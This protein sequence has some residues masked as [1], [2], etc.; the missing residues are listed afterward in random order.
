MYFQV[1]TFYGLEVKAWTEIQSEKLA[2]S[3]IKGR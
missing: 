2:I 3:E 1:D